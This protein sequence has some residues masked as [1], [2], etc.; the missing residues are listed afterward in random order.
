MKN[1]TLPLFSV[2]VY[3]A[4][5]S[6]NIFIYCLKLWH[7][8]EVYRRFSVGVPDAF[9]CDK[10]DYADDGGGGE[11]RI[12]NLPRFAPDSEVREKPAVVN[13]YLA[14]N[15]RSH[16]SVNRGGVLNRRVPELI[17]S[18]VC[19]RA[20][21]YR[22]L[23]YNLFGRGVEM[24]FN[25]IAHALFGH[26]ERPGSYKADYSGVGGGDDEEEESRL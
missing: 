12:A 25:G 18:G 10:K 1:S 22:V 16:G 19:S 3:F 21:G 9:V 17:E 7:I 20:D 11:G 8:P 13:V 14:D 2:Y 26:A 5:L 15:I 4:I 6:I 24:L 23:G